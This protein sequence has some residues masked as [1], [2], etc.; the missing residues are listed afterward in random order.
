MVT[1]KWS[2]FGSSD[3][4]RTERASKIERTA[5]V[6]QHQPQKKVASGEDRSSSLG[7]AP[8]QQTGG[9]E[10]VPRIVSF[11]PH[12]PEKDARQ[13]TRPHRNG[14]MSARVNRAFASCSAPPIF[15][16][17]ALAVPLKK[18]QGMRD[19]P[20][21]PSKGNPSTCTAAAARLFLALFGAMWPGCCL[22][23]STKNYILGSG[24]GL[25]LLKTNLGSCSRLVLVGSLNLFPT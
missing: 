1:W 20:P 3:R 8:Q 12:A 11:A 6:A 23:E 19:F 14:A 9:S 21:I 10:G 2:P 24:C 25:L 22:V 4:H 15:R 5:V 18:Y 17:V 13:G 7:V 16:H